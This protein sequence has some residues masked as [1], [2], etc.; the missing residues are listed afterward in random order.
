MDKAAKERKVQK[1]QL[2]RPVALG[3]KVLQEIQLQVAE[4]LAPLVL[5]YTSFFNFLLQYIV[6]SVI[7]Q[8]P[9]GPPGAGSTPGPAGPPGPP[10]DPGN[11]AQYC[12]CPPRGGFQFR[13]KSLAAV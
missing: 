8:G 2:V 5:Q 10:G 6:E 11:D 1:V 13:R 9:A 7:Q 12:P 3:R 4:L